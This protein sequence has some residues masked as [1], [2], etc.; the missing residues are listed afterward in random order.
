MVT[1]KTK[2][3]VFQERD[4]LFYIAFRAF[5]EKGLAGDLSNIVSFGTL[6]P[7]GQVKDLGVQVTNNGDN[8]Q[9]SFTAPGDDEY[10]G[11]GK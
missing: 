8:V 11:L 4:Q 1:V 3:T 7:P 5:D 9:V 6:V 2:K 10:V